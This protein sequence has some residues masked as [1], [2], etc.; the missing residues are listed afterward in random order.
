VAD[1]IIVLFVLLLLFFLFVAA[2]GRRDR[3]DEERREEERRDQALLSEGLVIRQYKGNQATAT[4]RFQAD[5][6]KM[7]EQ[8]LFPTSQS[9][10]PGEWGGGNFIAAL[11]L[12]LIGIGVFV[13]IYLLIVKPEGTLTVTYERRAAAQEKTCPRCAEQIKAAALVC[14]HCGHEFAEPIAAHK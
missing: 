4:V 8:G 7:A 14:R 11:L 3:Q 10:A 6:I 2:F 1:S 5:A 9:W 12:C 13:L